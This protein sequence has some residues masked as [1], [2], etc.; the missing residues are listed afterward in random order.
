MEDRMTISFPPDRRFG[1]DCIERVYAR[2]E[3]HDLSGRACA[4]AGSVAKIAGQA[5]A[6]RRGGESRGAARIPRGAA[7]HA[8][9]SRAT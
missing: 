4:A 6:S 9:S 2:Y 8:F 1:I 7:G 3:L 5:H